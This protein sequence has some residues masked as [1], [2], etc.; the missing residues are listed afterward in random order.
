M[1]PEFFSGIKNKGITNNPDNCPDQ[2]F[3]SRDTFLEALKSYPYTRFGTTGAVDDSKREIAAF[4][5]HAT[6]ETGCK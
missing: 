4:F 2:S 1:T 5:A 3:Y 6:H